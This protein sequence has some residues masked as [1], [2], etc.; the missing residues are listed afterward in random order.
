MDTMRVLF[1]DLVCEGLG[2]YQSFV[3]QCI[4]DADFDDVAI[5]ISSIAENSTVP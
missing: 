2:I 5:T 4:P 3:G 1:S